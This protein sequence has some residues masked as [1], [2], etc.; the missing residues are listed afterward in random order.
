[1]SH[2]ASAGILTLQSL[3]AHFNLPRERLYWFLLEQLGSEAR[4]RNLKPDQQG[5]DKGLRLAPRELFLGDTGGQDSGCLPLQ[6]LHL[7]R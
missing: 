1:M 5:P 3:R 2:H 6:K 4:E 7:S